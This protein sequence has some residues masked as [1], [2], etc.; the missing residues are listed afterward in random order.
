VVR[1]LPVL[2]TSTGEDAEA[3]SRPGLHWLVI[4]AAW[5][6]T[7]FLP[8]SYVAM[9]LGNALG[10]TVLLGG[11]AIWLVVG[12]LL[13]ALGV[14][15]WSAGAVV[16]RFGLRAKRF[17]APVGAGSGGMLLVV[18]TALGQRN[19]PLELLLALGVL[20]SLF[21]AVVAAWGASWG[22]KRRPKLPA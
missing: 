18:I 11:L 22:R 2:Q 7:T 16:G 10:R 13:L 3:T 1:R 4:A 15:A 5:V 20:L 12:L 21:A 19:T 8:L 17:V 9:W 14:A 6:V